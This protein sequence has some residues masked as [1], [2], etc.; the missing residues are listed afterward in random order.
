MSVRFTKRRRTTAGPSRLAAAA[1]AAAAIGVVATRHAAADTYTWTAP[2]NGF[3]STGFT[4]ASS[5]SAA[6]TPASDFGNQLVFT[7]GSYTAYDDLGT[8][9]DG[10]FDLNAITVN[11]SPDTN[12]VNLGVNSGGGG[13][14]PGTLLFGGSGSGL[15]VNGGSVGLGLSFNTANGT[16]IVNAGGGTLTVSA[17]IG[18]ASNGTTTITNGVPG[19]TATGSIV[20]N[21]A[22]TS[23]QLGITMNGLNSTINLANYN[24]T[25]GSFLIPDLASGVTGTVNVT[26]GYVEAANTGG[27]L[28]GNSEFLS[29]AAGATFDFNNNTEA[30]GGLTGSGNVVT[31]GATLEFMAAGNREF[32]GVISGTG[33][34]QQDVAAVLTL[35]GA[36][37][38]SGGTVI[39]AGATL[40]ADA[41][42]AF[43]PNSVVAITSGGVLDPGGFSQTIAGL[44][45]GNATTNVPVTAGT[46]TIN[47]AASATDTFLGNVAGAGNLT[48][49]GAGTEV[50]S[51]LTGGV[52]GT[53]NVSSGTLRENVVPLLAAS[54]VNVGGVLDVTVATNATA[55]FNLSGS[56]TLIKEG[57]GTLTLAG[58]NP[59]AS[60]SLVSLPT[61]GLTLA[62]SATG[63]SQIGAPALNVATATVAYTGT[64]SMATTQGFN[65]ITLL[66][67]L[68]LNASAGAGGTASVPIGALTRLAGSTGTIDFN[69]V[70]AGASF[71]T[72]AATSATTG[73]VGAY[74]TYAGA[75][76][77]VAGSGGTATPVTPLPAA[78]Y[79]ANSFGTTTHTDVTSTAATAAAGASTYD[80]R[81]NTAVA[82]KVTLAGSTGSPNVITDGGILVTPNVG[83]NTST[84]TGGVLT[85]PA[86]TDLVV[87]QFNAAGALTI[88]SALASTNGTATTLSNV[89]TTTS[90]TVNV[91]STAGLIVGEVVAGST[92]TAGTRVASI[93]SATSVT[94]TLPPA[95]GSGQT[96]T[97]TPPTGLVKAG[98][99]TLILSGANSTS[100]NGTI[101]IN[102]GTVQVASASNLGG[103][104]SNAA[105]SAVIFNGGTLS[106]TTGFT[107]STQYIQPFIFG[108]NGGTINVVSGTLSRDAD[109][110]YGSG[111]LTVT[112]PGSGI[113]ALGADGS[114]Y[115]G[116]VTVAS[117][118]LRFTSSK[119]TS[120]NGLTVNS[121]GQ[122]QI[123]DNGVGTFSFA[124]GTPFTI[125][126]S[127]PAGYADPGA[128]ALTLQS[129]GSP[130]S[131]I[132]NAVV[133]SGPATVGVYSAGSSSSTASS[134]YAAYLT[135]SGGVSG[136]GPLTTA[137]LAETNGA[138]GV[139][140]L[141]GVG[142]YTGGTNVTAGCLRVNNTTG[143]GTG[144]GAVTVFAGAT[145]G[146][147]GTIGNTAGPVVVQGTITAGANASTGIGTLTTGA[148]Q[149][150]AS[151]ALLAKVSASGTSNDELVMSGLTI[152]A[153]NAPGSQFNLN[154]T[155][156]GAVTAPLTGTG[157]VLVLA[158]DT[159]PAATN[160]FGPTLSA[161]TLSAL[162]L[163]TTGLTAPNGYV[164]AAETQ[165]D[166]VSGYDLVVQDVAAPEPT[167][168]LLGALA[169][170]PLALGRRRRR[171]G[172]AAA[173]LPISVA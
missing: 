21:D 128:I 83:A 113:L 12:A 112:S 80:V 97:F 172:L 4:Q 33:G 17:S 39:I 141:T 77:A 100:F 140:T 38:Y 71:T 136:T 6:V 154:L 118:I 138:G 104:A 31:S 30:F 52:T 37:T 135:L 85:A 46:F 28:F 152:E 86:D 23:G 102:A 35:G 150:N 22:T 58:A 7:S 121:G 63:A 119:F 126:G 26:A 56:G 59:T 49:A 50:L 169:A 2:S 82:G 43:S 11:N 161:A 160:P 61:G 167:S 5:G 130:I 67:S 41:P 125:S 24:P 170:A 36:N 53:V 32:D 96:L 108:V 162:T 145:L 146:G 13:T 158:N 107:V 110:I 66:G 54:A 10:F 69:P 76:W 3:W 116:P 137:G 62:A 139:L 65:G 68:E 74:A 51:G 1:T 78:S 47:P 166:A 14:G 132:P 81:F 117:G 123:E 111:P 131:T 25:P 16:Q 18:F 153:S 164:L 171:A 120:A 144:A 93:N 19:S 55:T 27:D 95:A 98:P 159:E 40:R 115:N 127:G 88:A 64:A 149:W 73:I 101:A 129:G 42:F 105:S 84:L 79:T 94:L 57:F 87:Q 163:T 156:L 106:V 147:T 168:L 90:T 157:S 89:T 134:T 70:N 103:S 143:S 173:S 60:L 8:G 72:T 45:G 99:G 92:L 165:P 34:V 151:G 122:Y 15:F 124:S 148:Q 75:S 114:T 142:S 155:G 29:V 91:G 20:I 48:I 9:A 44:T 133:L 109:S